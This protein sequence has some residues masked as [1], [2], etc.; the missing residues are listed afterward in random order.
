MQRAAEQILDS[1]QEAK[2][3][4]Q[5]LFVELWKNRRHLGQVDNLQGYCVRMT[6][7]HCIDYIKA[8]KMQYQQLGPAAHE[9]PDEESDAKAKEQ[10]F[11]EL[12]QHISHLPDDEQQLLRLRFWDNLSGR[13]ISSRLGISEINARVR[14]TRIIQKLKNDFASNTKTNMKHTLKLLCLAS[15]LLASLS[16]SAQQTREI[17]VTNIPDSAKHTFKVTASFQSSGR[18][19]F[20]PYVQPP[21]LSLQNGYLQYEYHLSRLW[22]LGTYAS[23]SGGT[24]YFIPEDSEIWLKVNLKA[25]IA[26]SFHFMPLFTSYYQ[27]WDP[28][29]HASMGLDYNNNCTRASVSYTEDPTSMQI[30]YTL[31]KP[32][33]MEWNIGLGTN[34]Y[35][36][37]HWGISAEYRF[38]RNR[39]QVNMEGDNLLHSSF[40]L[41]LNYKF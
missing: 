36:N 22:H 31:E 19:L 17:A 15:F 3:V 34:Y 4:V 30:S 25:G 21:L 2:D 18:N 35:F 41:G 11:A 33:A 20:T 27:E 13:E 14:L 28:Y 10:L 26:T 7:F 5:D 38:G 37:R 39:G 12:Q 32:F 6:R 40:N 1:K 23:M 24:P 9:I 8:N 16:L 29:V